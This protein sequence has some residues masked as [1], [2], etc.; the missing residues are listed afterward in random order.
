MKFIHYIFLVSLALVILFA[1]DNGGRNEEL[2][3]MNDEQNQQLDEYD[4]T[5]EEE[6]VSNRGKG[7]ITLTALEPYSPEFPDAKITMMAPKDNSFLDNGKVKFDFKVE[8]YDLMSQ[9][10][11]AMSKHCANS[12]KGQHIHLILNNEP[13]LAKYEPSFEV[14]LEK[15]NYVAL[16]FL[17]RSYHESIKN[18]Q[19]G[20]L[21]Q[22]TVGKKDENLGKADLTGSHMFYSRPKGTYSGEDTKKVLLDFYLVNVN[23]SEAGNKV[24]ATINGETF[25]IT[26][27]VPYFIEGLPMG[28]NTIK[29]ELIDAEGNV[30]TGPFNTV[31]RTI[32]LEEGEKKAS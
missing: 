2:S 8:N 14:D 1:C 28:E 6:S 32:T 20:V 11:D 24:R 17:S 10:T 29:L 5:I 30:I 23:L 21:M 3:T 25:Y 31:E 16:A 4:Q 26:N 7:T 27:W 18:P 9:T 19:A 12:D 15:G 13:Y 22:F